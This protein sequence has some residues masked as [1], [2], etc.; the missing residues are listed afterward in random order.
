MDMTQFTLAKGQ[1]VNA[2]DLI[3]GPRT[4]KI[5]DVKGNPGNK[6]Q[7]VAVMF[8]G[9][10]GKPFMPCKTMRRLMVAAMGPDASTYRGKH[11]TLY[12]D[13]NV[14]FGGMLTG[15]VRI[16]H[17]EG[18]DAEMKI[19]LTE[20]RGK[21]SFVTVKPLVVDKAK[22]LDKPSAQPEAPTIDKEALFSDAR[23]NAALGKDG[24]RKWYVTKSKPEQAMLKEIL[25]ELQA[26]A[27][28]AD[29]N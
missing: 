9:D 28:K 2:D 18:I 13:P 10:E 5:T 19:A 17:I 4:I 14:K 20:T 6:E 16:S 21:R 3:G 29:A 15:G 25:E 26:T 22:Q 8:E 23:E 7:P 24:M 27:A 12:R 11:I 1:Q